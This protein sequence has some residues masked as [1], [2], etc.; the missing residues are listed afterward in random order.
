MLFNYEKTQDRRILT[1]LGIKIKLSRGSRI[2]RE[3]RNIKNQLNNM[4]NIDW[5]DDD[6]YIYNLKKAFKKHHKYDLNLENPRTFSEKM[7]WLRAYDNTSLKTQLA[8]KY[9]VREYIKEKIGKEYLI[10]LL[11]VYEDFDEIDFTLLPNKFVLKCNHGAGYNIIVQDK[12]TFDK[13]EARKQVDTWLKEQYS[14]FLGEIHYR[15]IKP[16]IIIEEYIENIAGDIYDYKY[17]CFNGLPYY[18]CYVQ[19]RSSALDRAFFDLNWNN[20]KFNYLGNILTDDNI[21]I[22]KNLEKMTKLAEILSKDFKHVR[23]DFYNIDGKIYF[24]ELTFTSYAGYF[25]FNPPEWDLKLGKL[26]NL[27]E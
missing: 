18:I 2:I 20:L 23:V 15:G 11:G 26:L 9:L 17:F 4:D 25:N 8:D 19:N 13:E 27:E 24:G 22:P 10:P 1:V 6:K 21:E 16:R 5:L 12:N 7:F 3:I 14:N